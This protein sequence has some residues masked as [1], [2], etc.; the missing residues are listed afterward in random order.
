MRDMT[1]Y[2]FKS[3]IRM[4]KSV[5]ERTADVQEVIDELDKLLEINKDEE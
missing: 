2:Q 4:V 1:D 5:A 3:I